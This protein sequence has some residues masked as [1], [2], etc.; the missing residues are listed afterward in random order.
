[1]PS[2]IES[3]ARA[4]SLKATLSA[5]QIVRCARKGRHPTRTNCCTAQAPLRHI[6]A[7]L[8]P[9]QAL[10]VSLRESIQFR[11]ML[12]RFRSMLPRFGCM[13]PSCWL[14]GDWPICLPL[15]HRRGRQNSSVPPPLLPLT[16]VPRLTSVVIAAGPVVLIP[17]QVDVGGGQARVHLAAVP[18]L[19]L[20]HLGRVHK[21]VP[22]A[23]GLVVP[24]GGVVDVLACGGSGWWWCVCVCALMAR[25]VS[26][27]GV[28]GLGPRT[29]PLPR[30]RST[31]L[32][33][34]RMPCIQSKQPHPPRGRRRECPPPPPAPSHQ[35]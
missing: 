2:Q 11:S 34:H 31:P 35:C 18:P 9:M 33:V 10:S 22:G 24:A 19:A 23:P 5:L 15:P 27:K 29:S 4:T 3:H 13:P 17:V 30:P 28:A 14:H 6:P 16:Q 7:A 32:R 21:R 8:P 12:P 26:E 20:A 25:I 1:M